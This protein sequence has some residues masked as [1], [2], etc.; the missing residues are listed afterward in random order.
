MKIKMLQITAILAAL[1]ILVN[2]P[3]VAD[4]NDIETKAA[5]TTEK[6]CDNCENKTKVLT[7]KFDAVYENTEQYKMLDDIWYDYWE[8]DLGFD[9]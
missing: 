7:D 1:F 5:V 9:Q 3:L 2:I 4:N 6:T 8:Y